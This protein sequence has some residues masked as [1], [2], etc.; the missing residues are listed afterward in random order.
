MNALV[1]ALQVAALVAPHGQVAKVGMTKEEVATV[2]GEPDKKVLS[3]S[4]IL[5][6][7]A[8]VDEMWQ[9]DFADV[10]FTRTGG[11]PVVGQIHTTRKYV[12]NQ[13][14]GEDQR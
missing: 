5:R 4:R 2:W 8:N 14:K 9:Y 1:L 3:N 6:F 13:A 7:I 12:R 10:V 11:D